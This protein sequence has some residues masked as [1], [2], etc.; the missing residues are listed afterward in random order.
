MKSIN[1]KI[2]PESSE[3]YE[4]FKDRVLKK[5][6]AE[7]EIKK[8]KK[9]RE[10]IDALEQQAKNKGADIKKMYKEFSHHQND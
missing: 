7:Y 2:Q 4:E 1:E 3:S 5:A 10:K 8:M 6:H 9:M